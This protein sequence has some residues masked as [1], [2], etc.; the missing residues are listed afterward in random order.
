VRSN[1]TLLEQLYR[2]HRRELI[3][4]VDRE[5]HDVHESED[6]VQVTFLK[7]RQAIERGTIPRN[8]RSWLA[9]IAINTARRA[10]R[11]RMLIRDAEECAIEAQPPLTAE[12]HEAMGLLPENQRAAV[13]YRDV[14]GLSYDETAAAMGAT[15]GS[16][17]MLLHRGRKRLRSLLEGSFSVA[18]LARW[19]RSAATLAHAPA[20]LAVAGATAGLGLALAGG[21][22]AVHVHAGQR[23]KP[24]ISTASASA[25]RVRR[26]A[27][28]SATRPPRPAASAGTRHPTPRDAVPPATPRDPE[29][30]PAATQSAQARVP[31]T[32]T[33]PTVQLTVALPVPAPPVPALPVPAPPVP[34]LPAPTITV[35]AVTASIPTITVPGTAT[36]TDPTSTTPIV[37]IP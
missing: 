34:A 17:Q 23:P 8:P 31:H 35:P 11:H 25:H 22:V 14:L 19:L 2:Q 6:V 21:A 1:L 30:S 4:L 7:A 27:A 10:S 29:P 33:A 18:G 5:L 32:S 28:D 36:L 3:R 20:A 12:L 13:V 9:T 16:V 37:T 24:T 15:V 26:R